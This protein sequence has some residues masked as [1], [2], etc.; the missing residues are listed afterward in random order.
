MIKIIIT[1]AWLGGIWTLMI[2]GCQREPDPVAERID[3]HRKL[4]RYD[5]HAV[6]Q[7]R[8]AARLKK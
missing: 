3:A 7:I 4:M 2:S 6:N 5:Q 8:K 1:L